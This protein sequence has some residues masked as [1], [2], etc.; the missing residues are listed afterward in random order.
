M[1]SCVHFWPHSLEQNEPCIAAAPAIDFYI[2]ASLLFIPGSH[3]AMSLGMR[4]VQPRFFLGE[5]GGAICSLRLLR[6]KCRM[7][8]HDSIH[9]CFSALGLTDSRSFIVP[10]YLFWWSLFY[11]DFFAVSS[12]FWVTSCLM[13]QVICSRSLWCMVGCPWIPS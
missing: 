8:D 1:A 9:F 7:V 12:P 2:L 11:N 13:W 6:N 10:Q 3:C 5:G 4:C